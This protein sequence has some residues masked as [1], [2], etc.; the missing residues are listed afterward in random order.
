MQNNPQPFLFTCRTYTTEELHTNDKMTTIIIAHGVS[1]NC[2]MTT[3]KTGNNYTQFTTYI[4]MKYSTVSVPLYLH[5]Q[6]SGQKWH[7]DCANNFFL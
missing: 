5:I 4:F 1:G 2:T 3:S 6:N 7:T